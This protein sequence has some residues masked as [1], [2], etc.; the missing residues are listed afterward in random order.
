L[1]PSDRGHIEAPGPIREVASAGEEAGYARNPEGR[2]EHATSNTEIAAIAH[3]SFRAVR[4]GVSFA[5]VARVARLSSIGM[6]RAGP[7]SS[8]G[9][10]FVMV[11]I[12]LQHPAALLKAYLACGL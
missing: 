5:M 7:S 3:P 4:S 2:G 8:S 10:L 1:L 11:G 9:G 6:L 12:D